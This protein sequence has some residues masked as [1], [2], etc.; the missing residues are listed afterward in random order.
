M[1]QQICRSRHRRMSFPE[2]VP[3]LFPSDESC[4]ECNLQ[5]ENATPKS[6]KSS[7]KNPLRNPIYQK[8]KKKN[9]LG[10]S[11][12]IEMPSGFHYSFL[13]CQIQYPIHSKAVSKIA[14]QCRIKNKSSFINSPDEVEGL[15][16]PFERASVRLIS[17]IICITFTPE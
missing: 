16:T 1:L 4:R 12:N 8:R 3:T 5:S 14:H 2:G 10:I 15:S 9:P 7:Q 17:P 13:K 11:K 6:Q